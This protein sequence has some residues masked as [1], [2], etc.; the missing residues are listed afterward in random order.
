MSKSNQR[1]DYDNPLIDC[2]NQ[3]RLGRIHLEA[4]RNGRNQTDQKRSGASFYGAMAH[5]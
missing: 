1:A 2:T 5:L 3:L 4:S